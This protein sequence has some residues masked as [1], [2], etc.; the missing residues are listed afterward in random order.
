VPRP[1]LGALL[2]PPTHGS[3]TIA[4][5]PSQPIRVLRATIYATVGFA[6]LAVQKTQVRRH[7]LEELVKSPVASV[8][9]HFRSVAGR[10]RA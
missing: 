4:A 6:V 1:I 3:A 2:L 5:M 7:E 10:P 8:H 9:R